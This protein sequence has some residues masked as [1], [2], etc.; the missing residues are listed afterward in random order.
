MKTPPTKTQQVQEEPIHP[1]EEMARRIDDKL[2]AAGCPV[3]VIEPS[4]DSSE[5]VATF[6]QRRRAK[7][8]KGAG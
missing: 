1:L 6:P 7:P 5:Y 8:R 3:K 2:R 4:S